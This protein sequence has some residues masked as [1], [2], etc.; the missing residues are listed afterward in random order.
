MGIS[1]RIRGSARQPALS[2]QDGLARLDRGTIDPPRFQGQAESPPYV[3]PGP[4]PFNAPGGPSHRTAFMDQ[5]RNAR[6]SFG[7][8]ESSR[9]EEIP[10]RLPEPPAALALRNLSKA[11]PGVGRVVE[12]FDLEV[13]PGE[14]LSVL[15]PSGCGK[16]TLLRLI[17]GF[18]TPD[19]GEVLHLGHVISH[20]GW[21]QPPEERRFGFVFQE[22]SLFPHLTVRE[23]VQFG[24]NPSP[25]QRLRGL[26]GDGGKSASTTTGGGATESA[27]G[28]VSLANPVQEGEHRNRVRHKRGL[29]EL[30]AICG[31]TEMAER[32]PHELSGGQQQRVALARALAVRPRLILLDEPFSSLDAALR[33]RLRQEVRAI[34]KQL[35][36]TAV[37]VTHDQEEA[38]NMGDRVAVMNRGRLEQAGSPEDILLRPRN[39]FV[40][41]FVGRNRFLPGRAD[42]GVLHTELGDFP[43]DSLGALPPPSGD[44]DLVLRPNQFVPAGHG[45]GVTA[46][47]RQ[48]TY[49]GGQP[50]YTLA[51]PSGYEVEALLPDSERPRPGDQ[52]PIAYRPDPVVCFPAG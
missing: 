19:G 48:V 24:L 28:E 15:G 8:D 45:E 31:L 30:M 52:I 10:D 5:P 42:A 2:Q 1:L 27:L 29:V 12:G 11:Y 6:D 44:L 18:E 49:L 35:G 46:H 38:V 40:A 25:M 50:L 20:P 34:L 32:Y 4:R 17:G 43:L 16:T 39:R 37:L 13:A 41:S 47:V 33:G 7:M 26:F 51:L 9:T 21:V 23:N 22:Q 14:L 36:T 3:H